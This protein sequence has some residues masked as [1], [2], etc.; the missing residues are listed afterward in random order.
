MRV[1]HS[2]QTV[3]LSCAK[4]ILVA[5]LLL[6]P[7]RSIW[8]SPWSTSPRSTIRC[9]QTN[10]WAY[11][12]F[13]TNRA[14]ILRRDWNYLQMA[15]GKFLIDPRRVGVTSVAPKMIYEPMVRSAQ[16]VH[17]SCVEINTSPN[18]LKTIF[19]LIYA[20][21]EYH[22]V[23]SKW[24]QSIWYIW[25]KPCTYLALRL[26]LSPNEPR[27]VSTWPMS[28]RSNIGCAQNGFWTY[29][30]FSTKCAPILRRD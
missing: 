27:R 21:S 22:L 23:R 12:T 17:L 8:A 7:N 5:K 25:C 28:R 10:F 24:F 15:Q 11:S 6:S 3:H 30:T 4:I 14:P 1:V 16:N 19:L 20:T 26:K 29:A 13:G 9:V 18:R 2:V